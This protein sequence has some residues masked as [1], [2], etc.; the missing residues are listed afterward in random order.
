MAT[1][2]QA[3]WIGYDCTT[4]TWSI[5]ALTFG[6][7]AAV[8]GFLAWLGIRH[9]RRY[10]SRDAERIVKWITGGSAAGLSIIAVYVV[11]F[12]GPFYRQI[13]FD[14]AAYHFEGCDGTRPVNVRL[15]LVDIRDTSYRGRWT[16]GKSSRLVHEVVLTRD[17]GQAFVIPLNRDADPA[18]LG[19]L[20][21]ALPE[22]VVNDYAAAL[23]ER[24]Q[25]PPEAFRT[26]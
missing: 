5:L 16:G 24:N 17:D 4:T 14:G 26:R 3:G 1:I 23:R 21:R 19:A 2:Y 11:I 15:P 10:E 13:A 20:A 12:D 8:I 9:A 22:A 18:Q 25:E 7:F 6:I